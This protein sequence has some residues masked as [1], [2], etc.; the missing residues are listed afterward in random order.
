M[1]E[2]THKHL[3]AEISTPTTSHQTAETLTDTPTET[4]QHAL[5]RASIIA[6]TRELYEENGL[7]K[8]SVQ[9]ITDR[10]GI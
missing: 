9:S 10:V 2:A 1:G 7:S 4:K 5:R 3:A 8:T 6:A